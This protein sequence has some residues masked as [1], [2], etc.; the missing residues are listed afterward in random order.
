M[1]SESIEETLEILEDAEAVEQ[2]A[3]GY[4]AYLKGDIVKGIEA[5][6]ALRDS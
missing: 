4:L 6:R 5:V 1:S 3:E 2:L